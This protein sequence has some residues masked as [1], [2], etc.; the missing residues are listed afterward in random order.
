ML[1]VYARDVSRWYFR[2]TRLCSALSIALRGMGS[3]PERMLV[4]CEE[5]DAIGRDAGALDIL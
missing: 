5:C 3:P 2:A 1:L 4:I